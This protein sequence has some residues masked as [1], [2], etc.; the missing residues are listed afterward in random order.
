MGIWNS[1]SA[2]NGKTLVNIVGDIWNAGLTLMRNIKSGLS[3]FVEK[4]KDGAEYILNKVK[5]L[6]YQSL[7]EFMILN[8]MALTLIQGA[9]SDKNIGVNRNGDVITITNLQTSATLLLSFSSDSDGI[10][11]DNG[12][13]IISIKELISN[14]V[15]SFEEETLT[16]DES[17]VFGISLNSMILQFMVLSFG[18]LTLLL[19]K[20]KTLFILGG[21]TA[22]LLGLI[23]G[24]T[25]ISYEKYNVETARSITDS[26]SK[27][28]FGVGLV[29]ISSLAFDGKKFSSAALLSILLCEGNNIKTY[30]LDSTREGES[31]SVGD[32]LFKSSIS[33]IRGLLSLTLGYFVEKSIGSTNKN[34]LALISLIAFSFIIS[35]VYP[36]ILEVI[37]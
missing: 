5:A 2:L 30:L 32:I 37:Y 25:K 33:V 24:T 36:F 18:L 28:Y 4:V 20:D 9:F 15:G 16:L 17:V 10:Y 7:K 13:S 34:R 26:M 6:I 31:P 22:I 1:I 3:N 35:W 12:K 8:V 14:N 21:I 11:I 23:A 29:L 19:A 27:F